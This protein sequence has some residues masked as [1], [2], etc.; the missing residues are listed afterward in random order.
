MSEDNF[1]K[2]I[3]EAC[4]RV[5][6]QV[7]L[8]NQQRLPEDRILETIVDTLRKE[9]GFLSVEIYLLD[10]SGQAAICKAA[11]S[12]QKKLMKRVGDDSLIG[13][14]LQ[15]EKSLMIDLEEDPNYDLFRDPSQS[16]ACLWFAVPIKFREKVIG[17]FD[18]LSP[19]QADK[20]ADLFLHLETLAS[21]IAIICNGLTKAPSE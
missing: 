2:E 9:F 21:E 3:K 10:V 11:T 12:R 1:S 6:S 19:K 16:K 20:K 4:F 7:A 8:Q 18:I 13:K 15:R 17:V 14:V 5:K